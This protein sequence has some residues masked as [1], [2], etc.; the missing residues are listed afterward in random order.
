MSAPKV[1]TI[2]WLAITIPVVAVGFWISSQVNAVQPG[3]VVKTVVVTP[4]ASPSAAL[5]T[6]VSPT[7]KSTVKTVTP[8]VKS[9]K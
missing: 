6:T 2:L 8:T 4:T 3:V 1:L 7:I 5:V 9:I